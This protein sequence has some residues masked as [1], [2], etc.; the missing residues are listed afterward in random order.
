VSR[1][2]VWGKITDGVS[3]WLIAVWSLQLAANC[4]KETRSPKSTH[5][6]QRY[7]D[8]NESSFGLRNPPHKR[9]MCHD[10]NATTTK[11][12]GRATGRHAC[13]NG[14]GETVIV[15]PR[16]GEETPGRRDTRQRASLWVSQIDGRREAR[17]RPKSLQT[18]L[19]SSW[20]SDI[21]A[22]SRRAKLG[23]ERIVLGSNRLVQ[24]QSGSTTTL[25]SNRFTGLPTKERGYFGNPTVR[26]VSKLCAVSM[27]ITLKVKSSGTVSDMSPTLAMLLGSDTWLCVLRSKD[28][29]LLN[30]HHN[31]SYSDMMVCCSIYDI[32]RAPLMD[33]QRLVEAFVHM[34]SIECNRTFDP[35]EHECLVMLLLFL[36]SSNP[37]IHTGIATDTSVYY[38]E[39]STICRWN[40]CYVSDKY[41]ASN[42]VPRY[43]STLIE[44][45]MLGDHSSI[46]SISK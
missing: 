12:R 40:A 31:H 34:V 14:Y 3:S 38:G 15:E 29:K 21:G 20:Q 45:M 4:L 41:L 32:S 39:F 13:G 8:S 11:A 42:T 18:G 19:K 27:Q 9:Q 37:T 23:A 33:R 22:I 17:Q 5:R 2:V 25:I 26:A 6:I 46:P 16:I 28:V 30:V 1:P 10:W 35:A 7:F 43:P 36:C 44:C 24:C